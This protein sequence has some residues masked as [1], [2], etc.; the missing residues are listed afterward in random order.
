VEVGTDGKLIPELAASWDSSSDAKIWVFKIRSGVMFHNGKT[1]TA[2]DVVYSILLH[3]GKESKS[4]VKP[5]LAD[6][7]TIK[8]SAPLEV[9]IALKRGNVTLPAVLSLTNTAIVPDGETDFSKGVGTGGYVL[10]KFDPSIRL[11]AKR[12]ANYWK[13]NRAHFDSIEMICI[14]DASSRS[15]ALLSGQ[16]DAYNFVDLKTANL[17]KKNP[18]VNLLSVASRSHYAFPMRV[19]S[20]PYKDPDIREAM[21]YAIDREELVSKILNGYGTVGNDQPISASY[22]NFNPNIE[23]RKYDPDRARFFLKR[24]G[25]DKLSVQLFTSETPFAGATDSSVLYKSQAEKAGIDIEV[26]K[27]PE[28]SYWNDIWTK[29]PL[30]ASR[31]SGRVTEDLMIGG[32]YST[33]A[34]SAKWNETHMSD[35]KLDQL[36][37]TARQELN[38]VKRRQMYFDMQQLIHDTGGAVVFAFANTVDATTKKIGHDQLGSDWDLDG[39]RA[40]ERWWF[41]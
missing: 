19:D 17:L 35:P 37:E 23:Q 6:I 4:G 30:C 7:E 32:A 41:V 25:Q 38:E 29:K 12:N 21:K 13:A 33:S 11:I 40:A 24:A 27:T 22:P 39:S 20:D 5:L 34:I 9:T 16:L 10:E 31:W 8:A 3:L 18:A 14:K 36:I 28:D 1:L 15:S 26:V 2:D